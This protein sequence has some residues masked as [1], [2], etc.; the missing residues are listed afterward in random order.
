MDLFCTNYEQVFGNIVG[1]A[2]SYIASSNV[3]ALVVGTSGG[4]DSALTAAI[5]E[6]VVKRLDNDVLLEGRFLN[7]KSD[8]EEARRGINAANSF[9]HGCQY[10]DLT[11]LYIPI[12]NYIMQRPSKYGKTNAIRLGNVSARLRMIVLYDLAKELDGMVLGTDNFTEYLL[13]FWTLH[14]D[15]GD[16]GMIQ[17]LWKTEVYGLAE[18]LMDKFNKSGRST[19]AD[20]MEAAIQAMPTDGLGVTDSDFDQIHPDY[21]R[22]LSPKEVYKEVDDILIRRHSVEYVNHPVVERH[23]ATGFKRINP[24]NIPREYIVR[25]GKKGTLS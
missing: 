24:F 8:E 17:N 9:C 3:R 6:E 19:Q 14:G 16:F 23:K 21:D 15:V 5:A 25:S 4:I 12:A 2:C 22:S 11:D 13:G 7:I 1:S 20:V 18:Y 10:Q